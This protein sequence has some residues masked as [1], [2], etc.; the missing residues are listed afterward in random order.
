MASFKHTFIASLLYLATAAAYP[1]PEDICQEAVDPLT[2][3]D[4]IPLPTSL[5]NLAVRQNGEIIV[6][7]LA[8]S[9]VFIVSPGGS[10]TAPVVSSVELPG[11]GAMS[12]IVELEDDVFYIIG[13]NLTGFSATPGTTALW[14]LDLRSSGGKG[15]GTRQPTVNRVAQFPDAGF[16]NGMTRLAA[17]DTSHVLISD[18][19]N[20]TVIR[21]NVRTGAS[22]TVISD[23]AVQAGE[24][25]PFGV[26]GVRTHDGRL[27]FTNFNK[28]TFASVP[29]SPSSGV[30]VGAV[31]IIAEGVAAVDDF[32]LSPDGARAWL[33][34]NGPNTLLE[35]DIA[36]RSSV[37]VANST[38][39]T[40][41]TSAAF[42]RGAGDEGILYITGSEA[43][44][45]GTSVG[46]VIRAD[47]SQLSGI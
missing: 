34:M 15:C 1:T 41:I 16:F 28:G 4:T 45:N 24:G 42:G 21:V 43:S 18:S 6:T 2:V 37:I 38:L 35:V 3:L 25:I 20:G 47:V 10:E 19:I 46:R 36:A 40:S 26:N 44:S 13:L 39:L 9:S 7:S 32:A 14:E 8:S 27:Y 11:V 31:D 12:G 30:A 23:E 17:N 22:E 29:I 33:T 5:E